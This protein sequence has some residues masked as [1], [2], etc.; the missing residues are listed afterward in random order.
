M[1]SSKYSAK[2][3]HFYLTDY[4]INIYITTY[5]IILTSENSSGKSENSP[6]APSADSE[7]MDENETCPLACQDQIDDLRKE[8]K[9]L[10]EK[11]H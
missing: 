7:M 11:L 1:K 9:E 3:S 6:L 5:K 8:L 2:S 10:K 4:A